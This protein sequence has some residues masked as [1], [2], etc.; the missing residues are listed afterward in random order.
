MRLFAFLLALAPA[1]FPSSHAGIITVK[2][3]F[4]DV[5]NAGAVIK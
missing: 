2:K 4:E 3:T 5:T 1:L